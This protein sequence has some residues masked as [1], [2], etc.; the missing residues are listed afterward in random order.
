V[1]PSAVDPNKLTHIA[2]VGGATDKNNTE[3]PTIRHLSRCEVEDEG[4]V[5]E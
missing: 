3:K 5:H 2:C 1:K 4:A